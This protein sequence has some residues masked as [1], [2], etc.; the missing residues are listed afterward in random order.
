VKISLRNACLTLYPKPLVLKAFVCHDKIWGLNALFEV[1]KMHR[2]KRNFNY[3]YF[4]NKHHVN[5]YP[6]NWFRLNI[7]TLLTKRFCKR[8]VLIGIASYIAPQSRFHKYFESKC[9]WKIT[10]GK[11]RGLI[12]ILSFLSEKKRKESRSFIS[13]ES[14]Y[15][16]L[17]K[18][19]RLLNLPF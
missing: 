1:F 18:L 6:F 3:H 16:F 13:Y 11:K 9:L 14:K 15:I 7:D 8:F 4:L 19:L 5:L 10:S 2:E 17:S 12:S